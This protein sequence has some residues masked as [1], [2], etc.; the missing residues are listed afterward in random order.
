[1]TR[2]FSGLI[3]LLFIF[4]DTYKDDI[5]ALI[6]YADVFFSNAAEAKY[7]ASLMGYETEDEDFGKLCK[8]F[9]GYPKKK[10]MNKKRVVIVTCGPN[11]AYVAEFDFTKNE[12]TFFG[13]Y[14]PVYVNEEDIV[15]TNGA[16]DAFAGGFLG[17]F[18]KNNNLEECMAAGHWAASII[19]QE[20]GCKIPENCLYKGA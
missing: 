13:S 15:D 14:T 17:R 20:R 7:F 6:E 16:G 9:A 12:I 8:F 19:I 4:L 1:V 18:V 3:C 2:K 5:M 11:P 10:N